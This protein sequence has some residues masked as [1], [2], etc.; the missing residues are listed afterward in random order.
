MMDIKRNEIW[1][2]LECPI[3]RADV[4]LWGDDMGC[5]GKPA[6]C[7]W[8]G[9]EHERA[10]STY[11]R[12]EI[13]VFYVFPDPMNAQQLTEWRDEVAAGRGAALADRVLG[14]HTAA[15]QRFLEVMN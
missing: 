10:M 13:G 3:Q 15:A 1:Q 9:G 8:C 12:D 14:S 7:T 4:D 2:E 6:Y 11:V 5:V